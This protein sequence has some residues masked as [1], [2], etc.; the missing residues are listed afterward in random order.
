MALDL[1]FKDLADVA[2]GNL[3]QEGRRSFIP[4]ELIDED[5]DQPRRAFSDEELSQLAESVRRVGILQPITVRPSETN[6]R[7][8]ISMGARRFRAARLA[9][10]EAIPAIVEDRGAPDR[11]SQVIEN[12]Q[13]DDLKPAEIAAFIASRLEA[14]D[15]QVE[16]AQRLG[17]P[18]DWVSRYAAIPKMPAFL[19]AKLETSPIRA[20]YELYQAWRLTPSGIEEA[21]ARQDSFTDAQARRI[22]Q[23]ARGSALPPAEAPATEQARSGITT[24][25]EPNLSLPR[26]STDGVQSV[27]QRRENK[28][29]VSIQVSLGER[30]GL[31]L[32]DKLARTGTHFAVVRFFETGQTE[33]IPV[34]DLRIEEIAPC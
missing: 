20:V 21:C 18:R 7:Y 32:V 17:K 13:R 11:Y 28:I 27:R 15:K 26:A 16:I 34:S 1:S 8:I 29:A 6:D 30:A 24:H 19:Q 23:D 22:S 2:S 5:P 25:A 31:L 14:G 10:L 12:I 4:I 9:G 3:L 33:E